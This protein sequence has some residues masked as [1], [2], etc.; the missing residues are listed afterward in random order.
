MANKENE[1][2]QN[3][4]EA[5]K[6]PAGIGKADVLKILRDNKIEIIGRKGVAERD[7]LSFAERGNDVVVVTC[8]GRKHILKK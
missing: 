2:P 6:V 5:K 8:D 4:A 1:V 7:V 3:E